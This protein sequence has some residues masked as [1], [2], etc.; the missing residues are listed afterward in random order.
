MCDAFRTAWLAGQR[1]RIE[2][3]LGET[4]EPLRSRLQL[5]LEAVASVTVRDSDLRAI[6]P[7]L[8]SDPAE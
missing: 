7:H 1:P 3:Y 8:L 5:E 4:A 6:L 2:E